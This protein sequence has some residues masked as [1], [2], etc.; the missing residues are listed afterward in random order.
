MKPFHLISSLLASLILLSCSKSYDKRTCN[1]SADFRDK[2]IP[3]RVSDT[4]FFESSEGEMIYYVVDSLGVLVL[5]FETDHELCEGCEQEVSGKGDFSNSWKFRLYYNE[6][7]ENAYFNFELF[8]GDFF[9]GKELTYATNLTLENE[10]FQEAYYFHN[11]GVNQ[12]FEYVVIEPEL[13]LT[14]FTLR[15]GP[16]YKWKRQSL[17][18]ERTLEITREERCFTEQ[19]KSIKL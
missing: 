1:Y 12:Q 7:A 4:V 2:W 18:E 16:S 10:V 17:S 11:T 8:N 15:N 14:Y 5:D 3:Q 9:E 19:A 13:G 6:S